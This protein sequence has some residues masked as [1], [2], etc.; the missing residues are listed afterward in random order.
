MIKIEHFSD[1]A[2]PHDLAP[3]SR[4]PGRGR[5]ACTPRSSADPGADG[6]WTS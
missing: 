4:L 1:P 3:Q 2:G 6:Y 5:R